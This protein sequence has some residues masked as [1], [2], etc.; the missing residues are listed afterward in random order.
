MI[1]SLDG[2]TID[3]PEISLAQSNM[4]IIRLMDKEDVETQNIAIDWNR[5][6]DNL[7][8]TQTSSNYM[9]V[10]NLKVNILNRFN[11]ELNLRQ[12]DFF[13]F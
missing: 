3:L 1:T 10:D 11:E 8:S 13:R 4:T 6:V 9:K 7:N 2:H 5:W 12:N